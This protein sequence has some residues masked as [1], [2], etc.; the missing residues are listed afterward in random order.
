MRYFTLVSLAALAAALPAAA[1]AQQA[2]RAGHSWGESGRNVVRQGMRHGGDHMRNRGRTVIRH[3]GGHMGNP[4]RPH[5]RFPHIRRIDR[6]HMVPRFWASPRF[7]VRHWQMY[8]F[9]QPT[10][11]H[12]WVRYYDDALL[13]DGRGRVRDGRYGMDWDRYG[14]RWGYDDSGIPVYVGDGDFQP[15]EQDYAWV[16]GQGP[17]HG[18]GGWDYSEY[19]GGPGPQG[20][21]APAHPSPCGGG[22][23]GYGYAQPMP[24]PMPAPGYGYSQGYY[25]YAN[26]CCGT[27]TITETTV[28]T[29]GAASTGYY[30]EVSEA[31]VEYYRPRRRAR[32]APVRRPIRGERG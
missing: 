9:P 26:G 18:D 10:A 25:G 13:V 28:T 4:G 7:H 14:D 15:D 17:A 5:R 20:G 32:R 12:R 3:G 2:P 11:G 19:G 21:C 23:G 27:V 24:M 8:G 22:G 1:N 30:E 6:G 29:G 16:E 31:E